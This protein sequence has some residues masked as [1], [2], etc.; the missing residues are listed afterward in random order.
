MTLAMFDLLFFRFA[1]EDWINSKQPIHILRDH[2]N[3][4]IPINGG[5][6][7]GVMGALP[8]I[9]QM[10]MDW[11]NRDE[12]MADLH[13]LEQKVWPDAKHRHIAHDS[14]CCDQFANTRP[15]P[16]KRPPTFLH[17]GQVFDAKDRPR[18]ND[19]EGF[20]R[21]VPTPASCRKEASWV[22]G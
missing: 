16:T 1:V 15:F 19:I 20:I 14:Y 8:N 10:I 22:F 18:R 5:M 12:Y 11:P 4:C 17:V 2:V 13:F 6:W 7:G 21:G 3:H 9:E